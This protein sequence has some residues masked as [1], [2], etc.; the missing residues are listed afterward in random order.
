MDYL[1]S[2]VNYITK[3]KNSDQLDKLI[4]QEF[5]LTNWFL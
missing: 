3:T 5:L 1:L 2:R 4:H